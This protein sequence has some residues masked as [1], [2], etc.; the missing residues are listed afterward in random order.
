MQD[1]T[2]MV[3]SASNIIDNNSSSLPY[4]VNIGVYLAA[5]FAVE[6]NDSVCC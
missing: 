5:L 1:E 6:I 4:L 3:V 2:K